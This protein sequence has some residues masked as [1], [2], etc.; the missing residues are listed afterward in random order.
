VHFVSALPS[1]GLIV[2]LRAPLILALKS[3]TRRQ[4]EYLTKDLY[5]ES[6]KKTKTR[7]NDKNDLAFV[8]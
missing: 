2:F 4:T 8:L 3:L 6:T 1:A 5:H 7:N